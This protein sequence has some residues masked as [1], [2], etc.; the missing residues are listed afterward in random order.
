[1]I[2]RRDTK[3][4]TISSRNYLFNLLTLSEDDFFIF[5]Y[6]SYPKIRK[7]SERFNEVFKNSDNL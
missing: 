1:M 5:I 4:L 6:K 7:I 2:A 3:V